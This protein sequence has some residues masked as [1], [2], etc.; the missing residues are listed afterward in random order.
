M[1]ILDCESNDSMHSSL[2]SIL[3]VK[4]SALESMFDDIDL[5]A[6]YSSQAP[7]MQSDDYLFSEILKK[8]QP[9]VFDRVHWFHLTRTFD[10]NDFTEGI[11]PLG[12][13][14][15]SIWDFL[16][17][18]LDRQLSKRQWK[19]F[20][21][22]GII[23]NKSH[24]SFLYH[25]KT[26][27]RVHWGP[28]AILIR[29]NAFKPDE[30]HHHDYF[31]VP[32]IIED[33]CIVLQES[34]SVDLLPTFNEKTRPCIVKF[35]DGKADPYYLKAAIFHLY[36]IRKNDRCIAVTCCTTSFDGGGKRIPNNSILSI[37]F[38]DYTPV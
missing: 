18:L 12:Q 37:E 3:G 36:H 22:N 6:V 7:S 25:M 4:R 28:Y 27:D 15:N 19:E 20:R 2:E 33:I 29:D 11:L 21:T 24:Y 5:D 16:Y 31:R 13:C 8:T 34:H 23:G 17:S 9:G 35:V 32:E 38:P 14:I 30:L 26:S 10:G 1:K